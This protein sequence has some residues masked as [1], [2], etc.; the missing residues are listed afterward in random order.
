MF[1]YCSYVV[2]GTLQVPQMQIIP[3][4]IENTTQGCRELISGKSL[5]AIHWS[6]GRHR[7]SFSWCILIIL[8][9]SRCQSVWLILLYIF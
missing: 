1:T 3:I 2:G 7:N 6:G 5:V 9:Y 8:M 4:I